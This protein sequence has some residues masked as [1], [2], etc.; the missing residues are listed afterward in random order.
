MKK[1]ELSIQVKRS[2][3]GLGLF[4]KEPI[5]KGA[6]IIEYTG[7]RIGLD[8]ANRR[9]GMYLFE[10]TPKRFIDGKGRENTARY[11]NHA[12]GKAA[13]CD[14][15]IMAGRIWIYA[16]KNIKAGEQLSYDYG[17][18]MFDAYIKPRGCKCARCQGLV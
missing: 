10:V 8:E 14:V 1:P 17:K 11:I 6:R 18:E 7:E 16:R 13:N 3:T 2:E 5:A 9:G 4:A 15:D 12:C